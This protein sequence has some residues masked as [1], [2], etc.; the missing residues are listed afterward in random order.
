MSLYFV[1]SMLS[2]LVLWNFSSFLSPSLT[3]ALMTFQVSYHYWLLTNLARLGP[4]STYVFMFHVLLRSNLIFAILAQNRSSWAL[5]DMFFQALFVKLSLT[6]ATWCFC[7]KLSLIFTEEIPS[8]VIDLLYRP[9]GRTF[10]TFECFYSNK[11][12][13][14]LFYLQGKTWGNFSI[15]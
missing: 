14:N 15:L 6:L 7:V 11:P 1:P 8:A 4:R 13:A 5:I 10:Y 12:N 9:F 3:S 2:I